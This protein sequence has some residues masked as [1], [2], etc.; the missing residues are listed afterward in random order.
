VDE[1]SRSRH[2]TTLAKPHRTRDSPED[3]PYEQAVSAFAARAADI[4]AG[5]APTGILGGA[6]FL[7]GG[8]TGARIT[9]NTFSNGHDDG[10][11]IGGGPNDHALI[12]GNTIS[13]NATD[14]IDTGDDNALRNSLIGS[15]TVTGNGEHG[16]RLTGT[17]NT[18]NFLTAN[19]VTLN[20]VSNADNCDDP[21]PASNTW[22]ANNAECVP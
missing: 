22:F 19:S 17:G 15:N 13:N 9:Q 20:G 2:T 8:N 7:D 12:Y 1:S 11:G 16:I 18:G 5:Q 10:I 4:G 3:C 21:D 14:G 6:V